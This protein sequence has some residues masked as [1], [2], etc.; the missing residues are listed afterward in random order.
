MRPEPQVQG[1]ALEG[2]VLGQGGRPLGR[3]KAGG[4]LTSCPKSQLRSLFGGPDSDK[5]VHFLISPTAGMQQPGPIL[6]LSSL[7]LTPPLCAGMAL[8]PPAGWLLGLSQPLD[9]PSTDSSHS[10]LARAPASEPSEPPAL[11]WEILF[12]FVQ[13]AEPR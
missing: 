8:C 12:S 5:P 1:T 10:S 11:A 6:L 7:T 3:G 9:P 4:H 2:C 13:G